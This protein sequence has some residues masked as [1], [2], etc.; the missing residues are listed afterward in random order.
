MEGWW[1]S[2]KLDGWRTHIVRDKSHKIISG[3]EKADWAKGSD[4]S[5]FFLSSRN[6]SK[7]GPTVIPV[8]DEII[9]S[10]EKLNLADLTILDSEWMA[11]RTIGEC[12]E[13]IFIFDVIWLSNQW[14]GNLP[15]M[16]RKR[17]R[18]DLLKDKLTFVLD[19]PEEVQNDIAGFFKKMTQIPWTEG[20]VGKHCDSKL[21]SGFDEPIKNPW[22][23][24]IK[25][26]DGASGRDTVRNLT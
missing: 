7:G 9:Q 15:Y 17:I 10:V 12:P 18:E 14:L 21:K 25:W 5:L 26:R 3:F 24:K 23:V 6:M 11:R 2:S 19:I 20:M 13:K 8:C 16:E 4:H 1:F 22:W